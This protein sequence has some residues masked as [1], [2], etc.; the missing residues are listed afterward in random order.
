[1][2]FVYVCK[3]GPNEELRYS[4]RSVLASF[5]DATIWV[6]GGKP[7]WYSGNFIS[8]RRSHNTYDTVS[9]NLS[10]LISCPDISEEFVL[11]NDDF[12]ITKKIDSIDSYHRGKMLDMIS[13][14][15]NRCAQFGMDRS[16]LNKVERTYKFI[17]N[18]Y[19][20]SEPI[21]YEIHMPMKMEKSKLE[22]LINQPALWRSNYGNRYNVGGIE[23]QDVKV[24]GS[25]WYISFDYLNT[26]S[27]YVS[28][29]DDSFESMKPW[30]HNLFPNPSK[31]ELDM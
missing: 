9:K 15:S 16:Y 28:S 22:P 1:M 18:K 17:K 8:V 29:N 2:D 4:I 10:A 24:Y 25:E 14:L 11:M 23:S 20:V 21:N 19:E 31:H 26:D 30:L 12:F 7:G 6:I 13:V 27:I 3:Q 5:P